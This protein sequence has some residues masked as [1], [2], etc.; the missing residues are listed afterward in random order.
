MEYGVSIIA[1]EDCKSIPSMH[2]AL[3][4]KDFERQTTFMWKILPCIDICG[5]QNG[6]HN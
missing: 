6:Y 4:P 1:I 3:P 2:M 5:P